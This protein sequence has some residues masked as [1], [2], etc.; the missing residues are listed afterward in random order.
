VE[1][2]DRLTTVAFRLHRTERQG[3]MGRYRLEDEKSA[4]AVFAA[5][6]VDG[7]EA[8]DGDEFELACLQL[9]LCVDPCCFVC[10]IYA[11]GPGQ[12]GLDSTTR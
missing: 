7:S 3:E 6:D 8:L 10:V 12:G 9:G 11:A 1:S 2:S 5:L 4:A